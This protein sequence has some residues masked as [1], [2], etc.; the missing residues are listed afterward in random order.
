MAARARACAGRGYSAKHVL[1]S[2]VLAEARRLRALFGDTRPIVLAF[3][4]GGFAFH[5]LDALDAEDF[6]YVVYVPSS[7]K[8]ADLA[9]IAPPDDGVGELAWTHQKLHH[10]ARLLV[11]RDGDDFVPIATNL[12]TVV[13]ADE[14][15]RLL[16]RCRGAQEN[17][18]K[19]ARAHAHIDRLVDRGGATRAPDDRQ[20]DNPARAALKTELAD[21][22]RRE[23]ELAKERPTATGRSRNEIDRDRFRTGVDRQL[24][25]LELKRTPAQVP[26]VSMDSTAQRATLDTANRALLQPLKLATENA[27]R[28]LLASLH[29]GLAPTDATYDADAV[30]RTLDAVLRAPGTVR[31]DTDAVYVTLDLPLPPTA[32]ARLDAA[33]R[34]IVDRL[35]L[36]TDGRRRLAVRLAPRPTR[37][38]L[39]HQVSTMK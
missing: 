39:P 37:S 25:L 3:D 12:T 19:A 4:R 36:F 8:L 5:T 31:F 10:R 23:A 27:R 2:H 24:A 18:F 22:R 29:A 21:L 7:V 15:V 14:T 6:G 33:L 32:H 30:A 9:T 35:F 13:D 38:T 28:W 26:R 16:R 34:G 20:I 1:S 11:E 17:A